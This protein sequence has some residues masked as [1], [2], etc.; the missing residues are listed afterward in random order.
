MNWLDMRTVMVSHLIG[1]F[2][3]I[4]VLILLWRQNRARF[5]GLGYW[6]Q[7]FILQMVG[8]ALIIARGEIPD[9][10]SITVANA[11]MIASMIVI[12][13]GLNRFV[14]RRWSPFPAYV[15][16]AAFT[17]GHAYFTYV[18]TSLAARTI[19]LA[20]A[21]LLISLYGVALVWRRPPAGERRIT[22]GVGWVYAALALT[23]AIR[24]AGVLAGSIAVNDF[25]RTGLFDIFVL[26]IYLMLFILMAFALT[27]M[28]NN[29]LIGENK[30]EED[31]F[32]YIF[33]YS[34]VA[35]SITLPGGELHVNQA[36]GDMLDY[37]VEEL[38]NRNWRDITHPDDIEMNQQALEPVLAGEKGSARFVKRYLR[39]DGSFV[40]GDVNTS[41]RRSPDG[42]PLYFL[43]TIIDI[44][45][46]VKA[47]EELN[48]S[49]REKV[50][51]MSELK[52]RVKNSLTV[53]SSLLGLSLEDT[54]DPR[55]AAI[56]ADLRTRIGSI[57]RAYEQLDR[58]GRADVIHFRSYILE[59]VESL[60]SSYGPPDRRIRVSTRLEDL[61][62]STKKAL[63]LG[64]I[65]NELIINAFK[66]AYPAGVS[67][68]IRVE[69]SS[70][71]GGGVL[72]VSDDGAGR[73]AAAGRPGREGTGLKMVELL[74]A[75]IDAEL[76]WPEGPG[77]TAVVSF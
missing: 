44:T 18:R 61:A 8:T 36:F 59:L 56:I 25:F 52:H 31:K 55:F 16:L 73:A 20:A 62:L 2:L 42:A 60:A 71:P 68:E 67:G 38:E 19:L 26:L 41:L 34:V 39:K 28:V 70:R 49:L 27:L 76:A 14:N 69:L 11:L 63:P 58:T 65:L 77:T 4:L 21:S 1:T 46:R 47:E 7:G 54:P 48:Q 13:M 43:T 53:V 32:K 6:W 22:K 15:L 37:T 9:W 10:L 35:K 29:R 50:L 51:L 74:V 75:Q 12:L 30:I 5:A 17:A 45:E 3:C 64:L 33:D 66:Y 57:S 23:S 40:W 24:I 72:S